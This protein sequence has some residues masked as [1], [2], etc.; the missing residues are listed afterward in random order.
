MLSIEKN[1]NF[2]GSLSLCNFDVHD[3]AQISTILPIEIGRFVQ[4]F[5]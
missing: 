4:G 2:D 1:S 3:S 5:A